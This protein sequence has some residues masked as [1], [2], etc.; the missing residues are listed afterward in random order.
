MKIKTAKMGYED[1]LALPVLVHEKPIKQ[2][3]LFRIILLLLSV[4]DLWMTR[5]TYHTTGLEKLEKDEPC[6]VLMNHSS[7][8]DLKIASRL[9]VTRL[10]HVICTSDGF[11]GRRWLMTDFYWYEIGD[12]I[13]IGDARAQYYCFPQNCG[14]IVAKTR[15]A[16]EELYKMVKV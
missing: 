14:D 9:L 6:L 7:F 3:M 2:R 1:V 11:V 10:F 15:L 4:W 5:F 8:I 13:C 16:T 12:V